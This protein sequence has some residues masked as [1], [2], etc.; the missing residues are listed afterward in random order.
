VE[1]EGK[2]LALVIDHDLGGGANLY[3]HSLMDRLAA[4]SFAPI[5]LSAHHGIL[6]YQLAVRQGGRVRTAH[7][8]DL[9][10]LFAALSGANFKRVVFNNIISFPAPLALVDALTNWLMQKRTEQFLF[11]VHDH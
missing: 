7:V 10:V 8:E 6:A 3:R 11:L 5:L 2:P 1:A 9:N 4:E